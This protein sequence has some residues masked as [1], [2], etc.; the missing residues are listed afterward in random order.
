MPAAAANTPKNR[1]TADAAVPQ[2]KTPTAPSRP[3][4]RT[5]RPASKD[6][7]RFKDGLQYVEFI[8]G[9]SQEGF[10][11]EF[12][13]QV[14]DQ[15]VD[16]DIGEPKRMKCGGKLGREYVDQKVIIGVQRKVRALMLEHDK[17]LRAATRL[18]PR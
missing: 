7:P 4:G 14:L 6:L 17:A 18:P 13:V 16:P 12:L 1:P 8:D 3:S 2:R 10:V 15:F 11:W 5:R 9:L